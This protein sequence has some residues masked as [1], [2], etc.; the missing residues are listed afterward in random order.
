[1]ILVKGVVLYVRVRCYLIMRVMLQTSLECD[2]FC[3]PV[4]EAAL[5]HPVVNERLDG[6]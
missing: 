3:L 6:C 2:I 4:E 5:D 1:M